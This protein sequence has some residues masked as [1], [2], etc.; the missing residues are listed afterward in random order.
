MNPRNESSCLVR[1]ISRL[2]RNIGLNWQGTGQEVHWVAIIATICFL[3]ACILQ[4]IALVMSFED[5][6]KLF[7]CFSVLAFCGMGVFKL[8]SLRSYY[9]RWQFLLNQISKLEEEELNNLF[10]SDL[11]YPS[12]DERS[13]NFA[14]Y[15]SNYTD[16]FK[17]T[18]KIL[19]KVYN[20]TAVI[21]IL[22][23]FLEYAF[24]KFR[25]NECF[26]Y[27]HILPG[28]TPLD[29]LSIFGYLATVLCE[30][31]AAVYCVCVHVAFDLTAIGI[32][33][34]ICGQFALL[35]DYS[36]RIAGLGKSTRHTKKRDDRARFRIRHCHRIS[37]LLIM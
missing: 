20:F 25:S 12:D 1:S 13:D 16:K 9:M 22:S 31:V 6:E 24:C 28:W 30:F 34:F 8:N 19:R 10:V 21:F 5:P 32:M 11:D 14:N 37:L 7:E 3:L 26:T 35:S 2:M 23:P 33:I 27:P 29:N 18:A 4:V 17:T 36:S 15:V